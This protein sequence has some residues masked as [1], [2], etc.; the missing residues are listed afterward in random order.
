MAEPWDITSAFAKQL[1][2]QAADRDQVN[3]GLAMTPVNQA[4]AMERLKEAANIDLAKFTAEQPILTAALRA[5]GINETEQHGVRVTQ[6]GDQT[7]RSQRT[8]EDIE[9]DKEN[10]AQGRLAGNLSLQAQKEAEAARLKL[11]NEIKAERENP[12]YFERYRLRPRVSGV[13]NQHVPPIP[14]GYTGLIPEDM[15]SSSYRALKNDPTIEFGTPIPGWGKVYL[16]YRKKGSTPSNM[17]SSAN[18]PPTVPNPVAPAKVPPIASDTPAAPKSGKDVVNQKPVP[19]VDATILDT[20]PGS[21]VD[22]PLPP[23]RPRVDLGG[24]DKLSF[25]YE[26]IRRRGYSDDEAKTILADV[27]RKPEAR[28]TSDPDIFDVLVS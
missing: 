15:T 23:P 22:A 25:L 5:R 27:Q 10:R 8:A 2:Q 13:Q 16:P 11:E 6:S 14:Q 19:P 3:T 7:E 28:P 9:K 17:S 4:L 1:M 24:K 20:V 21:T 26:S 12:A 18:D